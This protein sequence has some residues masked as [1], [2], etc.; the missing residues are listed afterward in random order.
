MFQPRMSISVLTAN[1]TEEWYREGQNDQR[2]KYQEA[3]DEN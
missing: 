2:W 3:G 1:R